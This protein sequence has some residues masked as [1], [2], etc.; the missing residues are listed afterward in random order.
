MDSTTSA[1]ERTSS[2][3]VSSPLN[4]LWLEL[5][6]RCN[7]RCTHCYA[8]SAPTGNHGTLTREDWEGVITDAKHLGVQWVQFIGGEPTLHP[9]FPEL[10]RFAAN[11]G[12]RIEVFTNLQR[13][14]QRMWSLFEEC[15]V[16][17]ATSFY[18]SQAMIHD[19]VTARVGSQQ[20]TLAN[21]EAALARSLPLRVALI[22]VLPEQD[23]SE[24]EQALR[25]IGV[26]NI[27]ADVARGIGRGAAHNKPERPVDALCGHCVE[28]KA[29][30]D[31]YGWVYPCV[32]SRWLRIGNIRS[33]HFA[34]IMMSA[35]THSVRAELA[36]E[37]SARSQACSPDDGHRPFGQCQPRREE[38][39][40]SGCAPSREFCEPAGRCQPSGKC[41]PSG[42]CTPS[43][44]TPLRQCLPLEKCSPLASGS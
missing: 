16:A 33:Q 12:V 6:G 40:P 42:P 3:L 9:N 14:P 22:R 29:A 24:T 26:T 39:S 44:C 18:S 20:K 2:E 38:C 25:S 11:A 7:L 19:R 32:F 5:T 37:F 1:S 13:V 43:Q 31:P 23:V 41:L 34:D 17:L 36:L 15:N 8:E 4:F 30:V 28:S 35:T 21:I 27:R 10:V